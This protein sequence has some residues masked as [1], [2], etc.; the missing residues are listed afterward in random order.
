MLLL[1]KGHKYS[2]IPSIKKY[3]LISFIVTFH[4]IF[5]S[6]LDFHLERLLENHESPWG[7]NLFH[8]IA[9]NW[10]EWASPR[11]VYA[12]KPGLRKKLNSS[13]RNDVLFKN[14]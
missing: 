5:P 2:Y 3:R 10:I 6:V 8:K 13:T 9:A 11:E 7:K 12:Q 4:K 14:K 1:K